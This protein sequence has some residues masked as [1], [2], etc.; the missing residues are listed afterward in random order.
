MGG[1]V[2]RAVQRGWAIMASYCKSWVDARGRED[3]FAANLHAV[4]GQLPAPAI[5][6]TNDLGHFI[7]QLRTTLI[8]FYTIRYQIAVS[9]YML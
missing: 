3:G 5:G 6:V 8:L 9:T 1:N 4:G 2:G 7:A